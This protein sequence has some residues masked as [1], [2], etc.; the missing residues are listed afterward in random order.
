M[1]N[2]IIKNIPFLFLI[3][4]LSCNNSPSNK[5]QE[6]ALVT[7]LKEYY[8][9]CDIKDFDTIYKNFK[10]N[11]YIPISI[12]Y[13]GKKINA[14]MRIRGD[15]SRED[16]KKSLKIKFDSTSFSPSEQVLNFNA[17]YSDNTLIRQYLSS[18][19]MQ[20]A[21]QVCF[22]SE[23][24]KLFL[25]GSFLGLYLKVENMDGGFLSR[26]KLSDKNNLYKATKDGACLSIFDDIDK[27]WEKKTNKNSDYNDLK[28]LISQLNTVPNDSFYQFVQEH[29]EYQSLVNLIA[30]NMFLSN[31]STYY[32]NYYLYHDLYNTGKWQVFPWDLDKSLSYYNWM[33]Y[34]YHRTSSE[35]ESDNPLIERSLLCPPIFN[36]IKTRINELHDTYLND[37]YVA[38]LINQLITLIEP[39]VDLDSTDKI[40]NK[41]EWLAH[42]NKEKEYFDNH[43]DLLQNQFNDHPLSFYVHRFNQLQTSDVTF[44]WEKSTHPKNKPITYI[45]SYGADFLLK[46]SSKTNYVANIKDTFFTIPQPEEGSYYWKVTATDGNYYTDGF[47]TKNVFEAKKGTPIP[48][49]VSANKTLSINGSPYI[50]SKNLRINEGIELIIEPGVEIYLKQGVNISCYGSIIAHGTSE[51]PIVFKPDNTAKN[52]GYIYFYEKA[53]RGDFKCV[54]FIDGIIN[55]KKTSLTI[56]SCSVY[57]KNKNLVNG[58]KRS[59]IIWGKGGMLTI[60]NS[61]FEGNGKGEGVVVYH[62]EAT[63]KNSS[64]NNIPDAIEY[65]SV[66]NGVIKN[67][68]VSNSP[69]DAIDLNDCNNVLIDGNFLLNNTDKGIWS[70]S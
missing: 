22:N 33:P 45:L 29:F 32:H 10:E 20:T 39:V 44:T 8:I 28:W 53:I 54:S 6:T 52:W 47:N 59:G 24:V 64:F 25:N 50:I 37:D 43:Y 68:F 4:T 31:G 36:D 69:D 27:K 23:P 48:S 35:W 60:H 1:I 34:T 17:E 16:P 56:D 65:I 66:N 70:I 2:R 55:F 12:S 41:T 38:P 21:G 26:N 51:S 18:K 14:R 57:I 40:E 19:L 42:I 49:P 61:H 3:I 15:T 5:I 62:V 7:E 58:N 13:N 46:D 30:L 11:T 67:N 9:D 63:V